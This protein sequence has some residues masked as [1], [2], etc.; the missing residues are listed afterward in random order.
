MYAARAAEAGDAAHRVG[1]RTA[2]HLH[3]AAERLVQV[4]RP[5][6]VDQRHRPLDQVVLPDERVVGVGDDVDQR[7]A[8]S[9]HVVLNARHVGAG[10]WAQDAAGYA[11]SGE[12]Q[13]YRLP[14]TVLPSRYRLVLEPD[15]AS[16]TYSGTVSIDVTA[17]DSVDQSS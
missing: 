4:Q 8:D 13:S 16:A 15:L 2:A 17:S 11:P 12:R 10:Y 9:D 1:R 6:G 3:R 5:V 7:V 14:H